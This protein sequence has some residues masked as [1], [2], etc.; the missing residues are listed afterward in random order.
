MPTY[1]PSVPT[2]IVNL[3]QDYVNIQEN[4]EQAN[5]VFNVDHVPF[6]DV[7]NQKGYH[8]SIHFNPVSTTTT[9]APNNV[10]PNNIPAT[11]A[12]YGQ[13][14]SA[15]LNDG[16]SADTALFWLTGGNILTQL[17]GN[18]LPKTSGFNGY[19]FLPGPAAGATNSG[20]IILQWGFF[21]GPLNN[22][23]DSGTII[24]PKPFPNKIIS[25]WTQLE[26][27]AGSPPTLNA[28]LIIP[29]NYNVSTSQFDWYFRSGSNSYTG[30]L[31]V[32][33]GV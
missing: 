18:F 13:L 24:L 14:F 4:F 10:P 3:D 22:G 8:K 17:T 20:A 33:I 19:T 1:Q 27:Q 12:G 32:A 26:F 30:F 25:I 31:W 2:G 7:T 9:N 11:V 28:N 6:D 21:S 29:D 23:G 16:N 5:I 15:Q